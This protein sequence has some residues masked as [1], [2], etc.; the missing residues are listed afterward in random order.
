MEDKLDDP[1]VDRISGLLEEARDE[2]EVIRSAS[3]GTS[4]LGPM[5]ELMIYMLEKGL[6]SHQGRAA[7]TKVS[8]GAS[9]STAG[10]E[11]A[12]VN[13][14]GFCVDKILHMDSEQRADFLSLAQGSRSYYDLTRSWLAEFN[15]AYGKRNK[16]I[17][18][19]VSNA[20]S[21]CRKMLQSGA[22]N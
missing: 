7:G 2:Y 17:A 4:P 6:Q 8:D 20:K 22:E 14:E 19:P 21:T 18:T 9:E 13:L 10:N 15:E 3:L 11:S 1:V 12:K 5:Y 16:D